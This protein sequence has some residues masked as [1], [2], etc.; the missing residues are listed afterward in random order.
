MIFLQAAPPD[1]LKNYITNTGIYLQTIR[2][3]S[4]R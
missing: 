2:L 3:N 1:Q 4:A